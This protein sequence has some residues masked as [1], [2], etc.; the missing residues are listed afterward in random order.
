[1]DQAANPKSPVLRR[2]KTLA[3]LCL[4]SLR[5][6]WGAGIAQLKGLPE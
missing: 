6:L 2:A 3:G 4:L 1:M 5:A